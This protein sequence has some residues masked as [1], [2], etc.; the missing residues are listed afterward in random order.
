MGIGGKANPCLEG[1]ASETL[2]AGGRGQS[3]PHE[4]AATLRMLARRL[5]GIRF[6]HPDSGERRNVD[7]R[8]KII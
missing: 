4:I 7:L 6:L 5:K 2:P 1:E 8:L 3:F